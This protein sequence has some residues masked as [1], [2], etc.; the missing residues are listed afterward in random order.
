MLSAMSSLRTK[1]KPARLAETVPTT[2]RVFPV[3]LEGGVER[4][5]N[6][7]ALGFPGLPRGWVFFISGAV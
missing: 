5:P 1:P 2:L 7:A 4:R 3:A 6:W